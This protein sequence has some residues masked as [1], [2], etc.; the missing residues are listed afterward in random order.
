MQEQ[1]VFVR[2]TCA[3]LVV[4]SAFVQTTD[5]YGRT[6][7]QVL[8]RSASALTSMN[9]TRFSNDAMS[10]TNAHNYKST[11]TIISGISKI[12]CPWFCSFLKTS[13]C[14][15]K[16]RRRQS[17]LSESRPELQFTCEPCCHKLY[18]DRKW[19]PTTDNGKKEV[20]CKKHKQ[21]K[22]EKRSVVKCCCSVSI[23]GWIT[24]VTNKF[25]C[26]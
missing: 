2:S 12:I 24:V 15:W 3:T 21:T 14:F 19:W 22:S 5:A 7:A 17:P 4:H 23:A 18:K 11:T 8:I 13:N 16:S 25:I 10:E 26:E 6:W 1:F 20:K 9:V